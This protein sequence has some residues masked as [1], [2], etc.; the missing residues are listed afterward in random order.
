MKVLWYFKT[1]FLDIASKKLRNLVN[2]V[3]GSI[4][5]SQKF[6]LQCKTFSFKS[7]KLFLSCW[8]FIKFFLA[9]IIQLF[10]VYNNCKE[11]VKCKF[12]FSKHNSHWWWKMMRIFCWKV[13]YFIFSRFFKLRLQ[14][15]KIKFYG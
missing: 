6:T 2:L 8:N 1:Y 3:Y 10:L 15:L 5:I 11:F 4:M 7:F 14:I 12:I 13:L 9:W